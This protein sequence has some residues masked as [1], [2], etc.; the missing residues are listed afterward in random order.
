M[1]ADWI[2]Y[3]LAAVSLICGA[4]S[5]WYFRKSSKIS[6]TL[7]A[8]G[9]QTTVATGTPTPKP[10]GTEATIPDDPTGP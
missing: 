5:Y 6:R 3:I 9:E 7:T 4:G 2:R 10:A 1:D 8:A